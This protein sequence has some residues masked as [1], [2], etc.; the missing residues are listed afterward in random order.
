MILGVTGS[1]GAG[2][3]TVCEIL[4]KEYAFNIIN[5]DKIAKQLSKNGTKYLQEI[6][7]HF[8]KDILL[9]DGELNR[10]KLADTIYSDS[11]KRNEL[12]NITFKYIKSE[13]KFQIEKCN[14]NKI[15]IDA[16]LLI[17]AQIQQLCDVTIA[18][19]SE[20]REIQLQRIIKRDKIDRAH[21]VSRLES[22]HENE[23]YISH[24]D[25]TIINN[26]NLELQISEV[27]KKIKM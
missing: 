20:N 1:S 25:Y 22:Q 14:N 5:A 12:N 2:K 7:N 6:V 11:E 13:I 26:E 19:V 27:L 18:V 8:G 23:F 17:E 9:E 4:E 10:K 15:A 21:A 16:P 3:S 24:S